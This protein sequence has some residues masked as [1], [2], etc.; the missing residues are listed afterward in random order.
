MFDV[1]FF[2]SRFKRVFGTKDKSYDLSIDPPLVT[3]NSSNNSQDGIIKSI[4][5]F[6]FLVA[7]DDDQY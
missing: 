4:S 2:G 3:T 7:K 1:R 6:S 5:R